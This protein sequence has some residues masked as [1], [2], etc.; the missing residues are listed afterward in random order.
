LAFHLSGEMKHCGAHLENLVL[1][2]LLAWRDLTTPRPNVLYGWT[3]DGRPIAL[4]RQRCLCLSVDA[5]GAGGA[6]V[7]GP[8]ERFARHRAHED[9][10][11]G[12]DR[13]Y[14]LC[15]LL[16]M[17]DQMDELE[18]KRPQH[19]PTNAGLIRDGRRDLGERRQADP[20]IPEL[21]ADA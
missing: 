7:A 18:D 13:R 9:S 16:Q 1:L 12:W 11:E 20:E 6:L 10:E 2:D 8:V 15:F 14:R 4:R 17:L 19:A 3:A 5:A 21:E